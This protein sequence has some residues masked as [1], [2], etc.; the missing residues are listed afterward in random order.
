[1]FDIS[2]QLK[3]IFIFAKPWHIVIIE[4]GLCFGMWDDDKYILISY[5]WTAIYLLYRNKT[6][7]FI[8]KRGANCCNQSNLSF[9]FDWQNTVQML[10]LEQLWPERRTFAGNSYTLVR[11]HAPA[12]IICSLNKNSILTQWNLHKHDTL[13]HCWME[14]SANGEKKRNNQLR[15]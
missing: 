9:C 12:L 7:Y 11:V 5:T 8:A 2:E 3:T 6:I 14:S 4:F 13:I 15:W 10:T 1:M